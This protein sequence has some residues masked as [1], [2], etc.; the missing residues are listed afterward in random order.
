MSAIPP[1]PP[2]PPP[3]GQ[4]ANQY[5]ES[6]NALLALILSIANFIVCPVLSPIAW[7]IASKEL[8]AIDAGRRDPAKRDQANAG[9]ILGIIGTVLLVLG[10]VFL[11][12]IIVIAVA[13]SSSS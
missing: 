2:Y 7:V 1:V 8:R 12:F 10:V 5:P 3:G 13:S 9:R 11:F 6:S 4:P